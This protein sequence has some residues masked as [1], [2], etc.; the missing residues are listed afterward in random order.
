MA[1][2]HGIWRQV[3]RPTFCPSRDVTLN[4]F[5][6]LGGW[7]CP[8]RSIVRRRRPCLAACPSMYLYILMSRAPSVA[9]NCHSFPFA[10][11]LRTRLG[12]S[13][14]PASPFRCWCPCLDHRDLAVIQQYLSRIVCSD[15]PSRSHWRF[16]GPTP[17]IHALPRNSFFYPPQPHS[18]LPRHWLGHLHCP[19]ILH[20][21]FP[22]SFWSSR[23]GGQAVST[24]I[25]LSRR[26][27]PS[28]RPLPKISSS[29]TNR[30]F[31]NGPFLARPWK[32]SA[33]P[34]RPHLRPSRTP[35]PQAVCVSRRRT[36]THSLT[37]RV[38]LQPSS[39]SCCCCFPGLLR[40]PRQGR[41]DPLCRQ[42]W[43]SL[44]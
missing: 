21:F 43:R 38:L 23:A 33:R 5:P 39:S 37:L 41:R 12:N 9:C 42:A 16:A 20:L 6:F 30:K 40:V 34:A 19:C 31:L 32:T 13:H 4:V 26:R 22:P 8:H 14:T 2:L 36:R 17:T 25:S 35:F 11:A 28:R 18:T 44:R 24:V 7:P 1:Q 15:I 27:Q 10:R 3:Q 29:V